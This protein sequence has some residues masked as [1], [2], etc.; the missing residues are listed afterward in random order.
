[1]LELYCACCSTITIIF[2]LCLWLSFT[3]RCLDVVL[4]IYIP[5]FRAWNPLI[6][7]EELEKEKTAK[8]SPQLQVRQHFFCYEKINV[9]KWDDLIL[10]A[11]M[12]EL[13]CACCSTITIIFLLCL[14]Y[15]A[16]FSLWYV[17]LLAILLM[18]FCNF[19]YVKY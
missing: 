19:I 15:Y 11:W 5:K 2:L 18:S 14:F 17:V 1:M 7:P 10:V 8:M 6:F 12:L 9:L 4:S 13:Y 16:C 3:Y